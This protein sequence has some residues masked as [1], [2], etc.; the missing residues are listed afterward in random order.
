[1]QGNL[2]TCVQCVYSVYSVVEGGRDGGREGK[3]N[4]HPDPDYCL[5]TC[6]G[7]TGPRG[8][9]PSSAIRRKYNKHEVTAY[10]DAQ[11]CSFS[12]DYLP[13]TEC[14]VVGVSEPTNKPDADF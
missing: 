7:D 9:I 6:L 8:K 4:H 10:G 14:P 2:G 11:V 13:V 12:V 5:Y 3:R 1:M